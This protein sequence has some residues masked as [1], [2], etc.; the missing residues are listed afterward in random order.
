MHGGF[1]LAGQKEIFSV[2]RMRLTHLNALRAL[3]ATL[4]LGG[5]GAAAEEIGI[6]P[7]A[8]GQ[9][10]RSLEDYL[11]VALFD[12]KATG[13]TPTQAALSI[14]ADLGDGFAAL[15]KA[16]HA[17]HGRRQGRELRVTMPESFAENWIAPILSDFTE[18]HPAVELQIDASNR[19]H[20][21]ATGDF[22]LAIRYGKPAGPGFEETDLFGDSVQPVCSPDFAEQHRLGP[23]RPDLAGVPLIHVLNRTGDP[24]W[25]G[26]D[27][28]AMRFGFAMA[29]PARGVRFSRASSGLQAAMAGQGLVMAGF[30]EAW[31]ALSDGTLVMPF[32]ASLRHET[33]YRYRLIRKSAGRPSRVQ[34][35]FAG[36]LVGRAATFRRDAAPFLGPVAG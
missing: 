23:D 13:A 1:H 33:S 29:D 24:D 11:G 3:E 19:D 4:R 12:R 26:F 10:I 36:W 21:L 9:R 18:R 5:F 20:D 28:W 22:D 17:L 35:D 7:A 30:V 8:L 25:L 15:A 34:S 31:R 14:Q 6:T 2:N 27:G 16:Y 32:G